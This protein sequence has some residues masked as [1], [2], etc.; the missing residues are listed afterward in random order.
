[1]AQHRTEMMRPISKQESQME[2]QYQVKRKIWFPNETAQGMVDA[3]AEKIKQKT[4]GNRRNNM[5]AS[6][7][8]LACENEM[9]RW[10]SRSVKTIMSREFEQDG[11]DVCRG[12]IQSQEIRPVW[13]FKK[14]IVLDKGDIHTLRWQK[15]WKIVHRKDHDRDWRKTAVW[16]WKL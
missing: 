4:I 8:C 16:C 7:W 13:T 9:L 11:N 1:M 3:R 15:D 14:R 12:N 5:I 6:E 10:R 2:M